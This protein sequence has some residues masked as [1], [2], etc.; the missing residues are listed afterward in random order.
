MSS[1]I[2]RALGRLH[3]RIYV[4]ISTKITC[5]YAVLMAAV[6]FCTAAIMSFDI[7]Y[8]FARQAALDI[9]GSKCQVATL[10]A[11]GPSVALSRLRNEMLV[12]GVILRVKDITGHVVYENDARFPSVETLEANRREQLPFWVP[13]GFEIAD[14]ENVSIFY[15][16]SD[17]LI[18]G[19]IY[20]FYFM[21]VITVE[22][23]FLDRLQRFLLCLTMLALIFALLAGDFL[24]R[25]TLLPIRVVTHTARRIE[26]DQLGQRIAVPHSHDEVEELADTFN[27]M[28]D[29]LESQFARQRQ[30]VSDAS[31]ELRT[32]V[33]VILGYSDLLARWG[34]EDESVRDEGIAAIRSEAENMQQL[35]EKLLF[36]A[37]ADQ[38][39]QP[40]EKKLVDFPALLLDV[41]KKQK[42]VDQNHTVEI[43][44]N[45]EGIVLAD[46][47]MLRQM[48][49]VFL[50]NSQKYT[51]AG[52][53]I[54]AESVRQGRTLQV[55]L[56]DTGI[57]IPAKDQ[58]RVFERFYRVDLSRTKAKGVS[59]TG[60]GLS[61]AKWIAAQH[62]I[63]I[64]LQSEP[65]K[66]TEIHLCVPLATT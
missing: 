49:R 25:R 3:Q 2:S 59:G 44:R 6:L 54:Y 58:Q 32:P 8:A 55:T 50:E 15:T 30:F 63:T 65:G 38:N 57:G 62:G 47:V 24:S 26:A 11:N 40:L 23:D 17:V 41:M 46:A 35:I 45:D 61:I 14:V 64:A 22:R 1:K 52:G 20:G 31:H 60:L 43:C 4:R 34:R 7:Y 9:D 53:R 37:R 66:G 27:G 21:R 33:T 16:K 39:R 18:N 28:L 29:R 12:P 19:S 10:L 5:L 36:L 13:K 51:P 48:L 56:G 42:T